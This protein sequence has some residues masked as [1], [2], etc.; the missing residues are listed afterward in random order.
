MLRQCVVCTCIFLPLHTAAYSH[1]AD[2][3]DKLEVKHVAVAH[4]GSA[5]MMRT[6]PSGTGSVEQSNPY[7]KQKGMD[8][9]PGAP[10]DQEVVSMFGPKMSAE[11]SQKVQEDIMRA[12]LVGRLILI[13]STVAAGMVL[14]LIYRHAKPTR[15]GDASGDPQQLAEWSSG[16]WD[17]CAD[18]QIFWLSC[19]CPFLR[20]GDTMGMAGIISFWPATLLWLFIQ[21]STFLLPLF[22]LINVALMTYG[23]QM[24]R[25]GFGMKD[26][27]TG[28]GICGD[29]MYVS[30]CTPCA[31]TQEAR[32]VEKAKQMQHPVTVGSAPL[33]ASDSQEPAQAVPAQAAMAAPAQNASPPAPAEPKNKPAKKDD[34]DEEF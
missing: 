19:C 26:L 20:W 17:C 25:K 22:L 15:A 31:I 6:Q 7:T 14:A 16:Y 24:L 12:W 21:A 27:G 5:R 2:G 29:C 3:K 11:S 8:G 33:A 4:D 10:S 13:S 1:K 28:Q 34:S 18:Q 23:R 32:H 30:F 9:P